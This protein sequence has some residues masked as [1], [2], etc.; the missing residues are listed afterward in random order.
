MKMN[1]ILHHKVI[2]KMID[3]Y[4][5]DPKRVQ[6]FLK[7]YS[8]SKLIGETEKLTEKEFNTLLLASILHDIGIKKSEEKYNSSS[9]KYQEIEGPPEAF[10]MLKELKIDQDIIDQVCFLI[11]KHHTFD[12]YYG[13]DHQIL[14]EADFLVNAFEEN[15][16]PEIIEKFKEDHFKTKLGKEYLDNL[17]LK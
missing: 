1:E 12:Q 9:G 10:K 4:S 14:I 8:F 6:H 13:L 17:Y 15:Y 2:D 16:K 11:S 7:V 5:G 3:Y